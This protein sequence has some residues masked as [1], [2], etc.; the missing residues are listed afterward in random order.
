MY[1]GGENFHELWIKNQ[2]FSNGGYC[3]NGK[4]YNFKNYELSGGKNNLKIKE[5]EIL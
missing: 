5:I 1:F 2:Y 3:D 4:G